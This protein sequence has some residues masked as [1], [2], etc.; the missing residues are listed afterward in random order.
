[1]HDG[2]FGRY[3]MPEAIV[4]ITAGQGV[5]PPFTVAPLRCLPRCGDWG[6]GHSIY[7]A[8][9]PHSIAVGARVVRLHPSSRKTEQGRAWNVERFMR[10]A[11]PD[12]VPNRCESRRS[13]SHSASQKS[14]TALS[15]R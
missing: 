11:K 9:E 2:V 6:P 4:T 1:M 14:E 15:A 8:D 5:A 13:A 3:L 10:Y 7:S 12:T